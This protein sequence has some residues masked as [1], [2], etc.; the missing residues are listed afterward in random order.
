MSVRDAQMERLMQEARDRL[1]RSADLPRLISGVERIFMAIEHREQ[2]LREHRYAIDTLKAP[3]I[4]L[5][6][7]ATWLVAGVIGGLIVWVM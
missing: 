3:H 7:L 1:P 4:W 2:E 6:A 5:L